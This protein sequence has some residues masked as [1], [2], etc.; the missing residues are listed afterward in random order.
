MGNIIASAVAFVLSITAAVFSLKAWRRSE[1]VP[2]KWL[3]WGG[4]ILLIP[5]ALLVISILLILVG[6][7]GLAFIR[8]SLSL[9]I[10]TL[11]IGAGFV[12][13]GAIALNAKEDKT[14]S[15]KEAVKDALIAAAVSGIGA[16]ILIIGFIISLN[17]G[18]KGVSLPG[19]K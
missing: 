8:L 14:D 2:K 1:G 4:V 16:F 17:K 13:Y 6:G 9:S 15:E 10:I 19:L 5:A 7:L 12:I 3:G 18:G 11:I